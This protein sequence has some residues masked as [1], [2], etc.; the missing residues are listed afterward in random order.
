MYCDAVT[1]RLLD[2]WGT[3]WS[4]LSGQRG[5]G[6]VHLLIH[7]PAVNL[8]TTTISCRKAPVATNLKHTNNC[9]LGDKTRHLTV[10][11]RILFS[12]RLN[13]NKMVGQRNR[14]I[15]NNSSS[16]LMSLEFILSLLHPRTRQT[17]FQ[18]ETYDYGVF[19]ILQYPIVISFILKVS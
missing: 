12:T 16:L 2:P 6:R 3:L 13:K 14:Y 18:N 10:L 8:E 19:A 17:C 5:W 11:C 1:F 7:L 4:H 9:P 15:S